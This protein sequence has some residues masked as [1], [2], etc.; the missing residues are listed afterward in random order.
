MSPLQLPRTI[1]PIAQENK[2]RLLMSIQNEKSQNEQSR[3]R[4]LINT[5]L[6]KLA[7]EM[8]DKAN[9]QKTSRK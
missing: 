8:I 3:K 7:Q 1:I 2:E 4:P 5:Y 9:Q 6:V